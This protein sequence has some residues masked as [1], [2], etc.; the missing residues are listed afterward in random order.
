MAA[1]KR[2]K[3]GKVLGTNN[4]AD[5]FTK[6]FDERRNMH[7]INN[8]GYKVTEGRPEDAPQLHTISISMDEY[9]TS[10]NHQDWP[11]LSYL[12]GKKW[13]NK[14]IKPG[15]GVFKGELA[16]VMRHNVEASDKDKPRAT[17]KVIRKAGTQK[18]Q[19]TRREC[20]IFM[21]GAE[22]HEVEHVE[23]L[24]YPRMGVHT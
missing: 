13:C 5:L 12:R 22:M 2:I 15:K 7:H 10:G 14:D 4:P 9:Q 24:K 20:G 16:A 11:W 1:D 23:K 17:W 3:F 18:S 6:Y 8:L 19:T 21:R